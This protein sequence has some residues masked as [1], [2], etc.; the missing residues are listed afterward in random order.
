V[1]I[2]LLRHGETALNAARVL[3]PADTPL[4][5]RGLAQARAAAACLGQRRLAAIVS[6]DLPRAWQT[7]VA[8]A[9]ATGLPITAEPL[10]QERNF[11]TLRGRPYDTLGFDPLLM[12]AA[13]PEG[14]SMAAFC[15][16]VARAFRGVVARR[17]GLDGD[18]VVVTHGLVIGVM[19]GQHAT[20]AAG[21]ALPG[22]IGNAS[23]SVLAARPPHRVTLLDDV[24][25]LHGIVADDPESLSGG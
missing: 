4:G 5:P 25:H 13:P 2:V 1:S 6:S 7:A 16:R 3:Q 11:G 23:I 9:D 22:R 14:E 21:T 12:D 20:L 24:R 17:T 8:L 19:L 10:L 18:V 15:A